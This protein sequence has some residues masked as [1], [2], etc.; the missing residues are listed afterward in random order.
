MLK[1]FNSQYTWLAEQRLFLAFSQCE[2]VWSCWNEFAFDLF[3][4]WYSRRSQACLCKSLLSLLSGCWCSEQLG[5]ELQSLECPLEVFSTSCRHSV[6]LSRRDCTYLLA[7]TLTWLFACTMISSWSKQK[8]FSLQRSCSV[9]SQPS[10]GVHMMIALSPFT[11]VADPFRL[12]EC[13]GF[14]VKGSMVA[15]VA[16]RCLWLRLI[17]SVVTLTEFWFNSITLVWWDVY[18][19]VGRS[20]ILQCLRLRFQWKLICLPGLPCWHRREIPLDI[21]LL[22]SPGDL[23]T[24]QPP[25]FWNWL[26]P[27]VFRAFLREDFVRCRDVDWTSSLIIIQ[28]LLTLHL[29]DSTGYDFSLGSHLRLYFLRCRFC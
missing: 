3:D 17:L 18:C 25:R 10:R 13:K 22:R 12:K 5:S 14:I 7:Q 24:L 6:L 28:R 29:K 26:C 19:W 9:I 15:I 20:N 27:L 16:K 8:S 1:G 21:C 4:C 23:R 11:S 2:K